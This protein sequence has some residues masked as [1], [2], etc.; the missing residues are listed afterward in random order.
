MVRPN[1]NIKLLQLCTIFKLFL[2]LCMF[3]H[4][5]IFMFLNPEKNPNPKINRKFKRYKEFLYLNLKWKELLE[6]K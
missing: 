6:I 2:Y 5:L 4:N 1:V 3:L